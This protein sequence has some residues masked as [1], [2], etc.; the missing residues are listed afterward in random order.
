MD[1]SQTSSCEQRL[2]QAFLSFCS[3]V[4]RSLSVCMFSDYCLLRFSADNIAVAAAQRVFGTCCPTEP[5]R[6]R[7]EGKES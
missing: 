7:M 2:V 4:S 5:G 3:I 1:I 6:Q